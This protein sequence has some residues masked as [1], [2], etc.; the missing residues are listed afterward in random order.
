MLMTAFFFNVITVLAYI[1]HIEVRVCG[2]DD[3]L[4]LPNSPEIENMDQI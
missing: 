2:S 3:S 1:L 4:L